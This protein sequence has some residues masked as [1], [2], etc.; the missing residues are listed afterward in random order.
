MTAGAVQLGAAL[1]APQGA[2]GAALGIPALFV[3]TDRAKQGR[4][5]RITGPKKVRSAEAL[6][7]RRRAE[8]PNRAQRRLELQDT[9]RG[10]LAAPARRERPGPP[11]GWAKAV[12]AG[13]GTHQLVYRRSRTKRH[14]QLHRVHNCL[15]APVGGLVTVYHHAD[16]GSASYG[17]LQTCG[18]PW[19]C[20]VCA[21][22]I[23]ARRA[24]EVSEAVTRWQSCGGHVLMLTLT[25]RHRAG[26]PL[27]RLRRRLKLAYKKL[28]SGR[29]WSLFRARIGLVGSIVAKEDTHGGNG[30]HPHLHVLWFVEQDIDGGRRYV[31]ELWLAR[32]WQSCLAAVGESADI[33]HGCDLRN[34]DD[35]AGRYIAKLTTAW[36]VA[37]EL[38]SGAEKRG[39]GGS[40]TPA[41]LLDDAGHGDRGAAELYREYVLATWGD[42]FLRWSPGLRQLLG[43]EEP[44]QS[45]AEV[46]A[47]QRDE[48]AVALVALFPEQWRWVRGNA[49][50]GELLAEACHGDWRRLQMWLI[51]AGLDLPDEQFMVAAGQLV[52]PDEPPPVDDG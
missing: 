26:L 34:A 28:Q 52:R 9:A 7:A 49:L 19:A 41:Q 31:D 42:R 47:E 45:D 23:G 11:P 16:H 20:P 13:R 25:M 46:A 5:E 14:A 38:A 2:A 30:W 29:V 22:K 43:W 21:A 39:R 18:S 6:A 27:R 44:E 3:T 36:S 12:A 32:R 50:R 35:A 51:N 37:A 40:R 15:I 8:A 33:E 24:E 1:Q 10:I 17:G 48:N 4:G